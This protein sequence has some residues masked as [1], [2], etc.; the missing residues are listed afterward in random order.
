M[1][2]FN[3]E[4]FK[5]DLVTLRGDETQAS[6]AAKLQINR[7][8]LSLLETG[9]QIPDLT[10]FSKICELGGFAADSYFEDYKKDPLV[11]FMGVLENKNDIAKI[12][13]MREKIRIQEKYEVI[14]RR[15]MDGKK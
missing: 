15:C 5:K 7:S 6:F 8:T 12:Q 3:T 14:A 10:L 13:Q 2:Q 9:K 4:K 11:Y 1:K